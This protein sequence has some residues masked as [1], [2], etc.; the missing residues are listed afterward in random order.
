MKLSD[1][2]SKLSG[3]PR[4]VTIAGRVIEVS[5]TGLRISGLSDW[6]KLGDCLKIEGTTGYA[7]AEIISVDKRSALAKPYDV[8]P[9]V[10]INARAILCGPPR[11]MPHASWKGRVVDA[12]GH[13][14]DGLPLELG[15]VEV[16]PGGGPP[17]A[18]SRER[19]IQPF[20]T[21]VAAVDVLTPICFGQRIGIFAGSGVGKT[22]LLAMLL[23]G[24]RFDSAV[25]ALVG[26][27]GREV[28]EL[29]EETLGQS[30]AQTVAVVAT[31]DE[32]PMMRRLA[33]RTATTIAEHF[34][35]QGESVLLVI[36]SVT[37]YAHALREI[38]LSAGEPPVARGYPPSVFT[39]IPRLLE[40][41]GTGGA[42]VGSITGLYSVLVDGDDHNEP[43]ADCIRGTLDGHIVL[44]RAIAQEGRLPAIDP[45]ASLSR[46]AHLAWSPGQSE[47][48]TSLRAMITRFEETKDLRALNAYRPGTDFMLDRAV[49]IVPRVYDLLK[50]SPRAKSN[51]DIFSAIQSILNS[52]GQ[53]P[54]SE[55]K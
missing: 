27:R 38:A 3:A 4:L 29:I 33:A 8:A 35:D 18:L 7:L 41:A 30:R 37:R 51:S 32:S 48:V 43:V 10:A 53:L 40:R 34:R 25:V 6:V 19:I 20:K 42:G 9:K 26:E 28:R 17:A 11:V 5:P 52:S 22:T 31:S 44:S 23:Q 39:D 47:L 1:I 13:P 46:L 2:S 36:D 15:T 45:L 49:H 21:G 16:D 55:P 24:G 50:Q 54:K 14:L 12:L